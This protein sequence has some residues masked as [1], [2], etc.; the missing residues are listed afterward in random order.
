MEKSSLSAD[1]GAFIPSHEWR[2][3]FPHRS[4]IADLY[5]KN[6]GTVQKSQSFFG[7]PEN[8]QKGNKAPLGGFGDPRPCHLPIEALV[9]GHIHPPQLGDPDAMI[10]KLA[11]IIGEVETG[12]ASLRR[13]E[14][15]G[16]RILYV[17]SSDIH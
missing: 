16:K 10:P 3:V 13:S 4:I 11:S 7:L 9:L 15:L 12:L 5:D 17:V 8:P 2:R 14:R 6:N 1:S